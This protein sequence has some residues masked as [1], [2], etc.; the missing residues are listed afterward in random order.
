MGDGPAAPSFTD[1]V[2]RINDRY[3]REII[4]AYQVCPFARGARQSGASA[5]R[6]LLV[7]S[8]LL[9]AM[10]GVAAEIERD[11]RTE[12]AQVILPLVGLSARAFQ[13][14]AAELGQANAARHA[15]ARPILVHAAFHPELP[16]ATDT[17][18]RLVP[19]FRR[20]PD[21]MIQLVRLSVL[22]AVHENRPRGTQFFAGDPRQAL[23]MLE[24][25]PESVTDRITRENH[26]M[27]VTDGDLAKLIAIA[28]D[29][30]ADRRASYARFGYA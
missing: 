7:T 25:R 23:A 29:I 17:P 13:D 5:K 18:A 11:P 20:S 28:D 19:F 2:L 3:N 26:E 9:T 16:Y 6:V 24:A 4:E 15:P 14:F 8:D 10:L 27:A 30:R 22:D 12:V 21:P 1:E